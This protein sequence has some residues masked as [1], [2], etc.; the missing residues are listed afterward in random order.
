[1]TGQSAYRRGWIAGVRFPT[2]TRDFSLP[3]PALGLTQPLIQKVLGALSPG[4][5]RPFRESDDSLPCSAEVKTSG[6]IPPL[7]RA[8]SFRAVELIN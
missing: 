7:R 2:W 5:K 6:A 8:F 1:M 4:E 3:H